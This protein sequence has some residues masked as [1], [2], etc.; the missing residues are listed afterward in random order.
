MSE[1]K[2]R[3]YVRGSEQT[4]V[5]RALLAWLNECPDKPAGE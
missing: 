3:E 2:E 4:Q 1:Q 5:S